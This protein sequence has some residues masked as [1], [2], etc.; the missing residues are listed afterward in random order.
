MWGVVV[1]VKACL[2]AALPACSTT[3]PAGTVDAGAHG[4]STSAPSAGEPAPRP[5]GPRGG[6]GDWVEVTGR[7]R[8]SKGRLVA[9]G[10]VIVHGSDLEGELGSAWDTYLERRVRIRGRLRVHVCEPHAQCL[11]EG[12]VRML[13]RLRGVEVCR[14]TGLEIAGAVECPADGER[15][16]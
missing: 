4:A 11:I 2:F 15:L 12:E 3:V 6:D 1:A 13:E 16:Q 10:G 7:L 8:P 9:V 14:E 5:S